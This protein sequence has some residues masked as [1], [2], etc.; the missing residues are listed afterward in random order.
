M[1]TC[2]NKDI[3]S[4]YI[5]K[6]LP[7]QYEDEYLSHLHECETCSSELDK[8]SKISSL[9]KED[10]QSLEF[11]EERLQNSFNQLQTKLRY[12][13]NI[14]KFS[15]P[16]TQNYTWLYPAAA[17]VF[18]FLLFVP[19]NK[20]NNNY[21]TSIS[22]VPISVAGTQL[23]QGISTVKAPVINRNNSGKIYNTGVFYSNKDIISN[24]SFHSDSS[25]IAS[26]IYKPHFNTNKNVS[27]KIPLENFDKYYSK[28]MLTPVSIA[29]D[30]NQ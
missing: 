3:H 9:L 10:S 28:P 4:I 2:P 7:K 16:K 8:L 24:I 11:N 13:N 26:D 25:L 23:N 21:N 19:M 27:V 14:K 22:T 29:M 6:E 30:E 17:A 15:A 5:D 20:S 12:A 18:A 1:S